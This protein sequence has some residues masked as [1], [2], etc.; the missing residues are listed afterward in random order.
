MITSKVESKIGSKATIL[1]DDGVFKGGASLEPI[2]NTL[3]VMGADIVN[4]VL[5]YEFLNDYDLF[6]MFIESLL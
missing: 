6:K 4:L 1:I 2:Q 5:S 3:G